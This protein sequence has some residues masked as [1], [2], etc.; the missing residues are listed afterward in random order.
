MAAPFLPSINENSA[1]FKRAA[2]TMR[3]LHP[4]EAEDKFPELWLSEGR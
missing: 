2:E 1:A 3:R 4:D